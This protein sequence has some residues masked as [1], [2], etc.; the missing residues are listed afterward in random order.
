MAL[1]VLN[2]YHDLNVFCAFRKRGQLSANVGNMEK[3]VQKAT[4]GT[5]TAE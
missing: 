3:A 2:A 5:A 4:V 1:I